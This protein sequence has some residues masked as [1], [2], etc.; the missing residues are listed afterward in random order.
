MSPRLEMLT[1]DPKVC[2][3]FTRQTSSEDMKTGGLSLF[4]QTFPSAV[5]QPERSQGKG[6]IRIQPR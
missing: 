1:R 4:A 2:L 6:N 5:R 3:S